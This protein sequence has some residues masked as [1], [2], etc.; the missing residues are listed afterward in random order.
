MYCDIEIDVKII[1]SFLIEEKRC[2][3]L[4]LLASNNTNIDEKIPAI[5]EKNYSRGV[6]A[7]GGLLSTPNNIPIPI[8]LKNCKNTQDIKILG[9]QPTWSVLHHEELF[10]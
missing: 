5:V 8:L 7:K 2:N 4:P 6:E 1:R 10:L 3:S 9:W